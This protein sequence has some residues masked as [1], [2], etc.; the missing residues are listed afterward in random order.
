[1]PSEI[2]TAK[3]LA[4]GMMTLR[5]KLLA[6]LKSS[7]KEMYFKQAVQILLADANAVETENDMLALGEKIYRLAHG[8]PELNKHLFGRAPD[9]ASAGFTYS[10]KK[11]IA[12]LEEK[13]RMKREVE[14][15]ILQ[16]LLVLVEDE[17]PLETDDREGL[18]EWLLAKLGLPKSE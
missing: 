1:M 10:T 4:E 2:S 9:G 3:M 8:T 16:H 18:F 7:G 13:N 11:K 6:D 12:E 17:K 15:G 5:K 14:P